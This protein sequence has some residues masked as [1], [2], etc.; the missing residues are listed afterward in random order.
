MFLKKNK[1]FTQLKSLSIEF[2]ELAQTKS[3]INEIIKS[4]F[5]YSA[6]ISI[7]TNLFLYKVMQKKCIYRYIYEYS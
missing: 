3:Y 6:S 7:Y 2:I 5:K 4:I 1:Y